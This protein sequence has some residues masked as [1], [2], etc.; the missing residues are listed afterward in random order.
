MVNGEN[1]KKYK[2]QKKKTNEWRN[3]VS[4]Y[5]I[6]WLSKD[7]GL[8]NN[9]RNSKPFVRYPPR[10]RGVY[11]LNLSTVAGQPVK[12]SEEHDSVL[13]TTFSMN[14]RISS[15]TTKVLV[16]VLLVNAVLMS[17]REIRMAPSLDPSA[18][19]AGAP[20]SEVVSTSSPQ[21]D[22]HHLDPS[23][24]RHSDS[25]ISSFNNKIF[26]S[27]VNQTNQ[28][29]MTMPAK[30][31]GTTMKSFTQKCVNATKITNKYNIITDHYKVPSIFR[32][33]LK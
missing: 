25:T 23:H 2:K 20:A 11:F 4:A 14:I 19:S 31:A 17:I 29:F 27:I 5:R 6:G 33:W 1:R 26:D 30:A 24:V 7:L 16:V 12:Q 28:V 32:E 22:Q 10:L 21:Q 9:N 15:T 3:G 8:V 18:H 13:R